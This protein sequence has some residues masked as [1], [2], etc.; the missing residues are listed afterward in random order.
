M[1]NSLRGV[2]HHAPY[3][4]YPVDCGGKGKTWEHRTGFVADEGRKSI[5]GG[6]VS[7]ERQRELDS[8]FQEQIQNCIGMRLRRSKN[9]FAEDLR[10]LEVLPFRRVRDFEVLDKSLPDIGE[11]ILGRHPKKRRERRKF[12]NLVPSWESAHRSSGQFKER[13]SRGKD[14]PWRIDHPQ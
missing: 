1:Y 14:P 3:P 10:C 9:V 2:C 7:G 11:T 13:N 12:W 6:P 4:L 8:L 5:Y